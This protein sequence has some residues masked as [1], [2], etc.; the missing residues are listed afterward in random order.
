M[1]KIG[2]KPITI[3]SNT[4]V[5]LKGNVIS[6]TGPL[7]TASYTF[8]STIVA[9]LENGVLTFNVKEGE[10]FNAVKPMYGTT[11]ANVNNIITGVSTGFAK[12]LEIVGLGYR[13]SVQGTKLTVDVGYSHDVIFD[14]PKGVTV[15]ADP[16]SNIVEVKGSDKFV[17]GDFAAKI[18]RTRPPEPYK[19]S[20][21]R[22]QGEH[23]QRKAG[24]TAGGK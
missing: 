13:A 7:G 10:N 4:K 9:S 22:Y 21:I 15:V 5:E 16:K 23:V 14:I 20:G 24:K 17:V 18:R 8:P 19:G 12:N 11:R 2:K 1:S 6:A 3:P